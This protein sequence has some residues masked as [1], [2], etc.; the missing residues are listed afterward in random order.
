MQTETS[1]EHMMQDFKIY[2]LAL[3]EFGVIVEI[4]LS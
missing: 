1:N 3:K 4:R 2:T